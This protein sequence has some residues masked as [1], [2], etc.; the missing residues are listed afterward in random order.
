MRSANT[1]TTPTTPQRR[2]SVRLTD[3]GL[4]SA[5]PVGT[6]HMSE[7]PGVCVCGMHGAIWRGAARLRRRLAAGTSVSSQS[8]IPAGRPA[9]EGPAVSSLSSYGELVKDGLHGGVAGRRPH[10]EFEEAARNNLGV[11][12]E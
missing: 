3:V 8:A 12:D 9:V 7:V 6:A 2:E 11:L 1:N 10:L 4:V 5:S